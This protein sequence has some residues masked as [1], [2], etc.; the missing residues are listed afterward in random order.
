M[1]CKHYKGVGWTY[2]LNDTEEL[3]LCDNCLHDLIIHIN[4]GGKRE[5]V[6]EEE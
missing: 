5:F 6:K 4:C 1:K 3:H 2:K